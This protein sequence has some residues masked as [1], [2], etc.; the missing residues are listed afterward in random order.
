MKEGMIPEQ[1]AGFFD[2]PS[3]NSSTIIVNN[4]LTFLFSF[5]MYIASPFLMQFLLTY[6]N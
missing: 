5:D 1:F 3:I 2:S 4:V 6:I